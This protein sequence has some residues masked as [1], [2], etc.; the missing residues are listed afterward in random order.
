MEKSNSTGALAVLSA[1]SLLL[2]IFVG[3][4]SS[5]VVVAGVLILLFCGICNLV[6]AYLAFK[7]AEIVSRGSYTGARGYLLE[8]AIGAIVILIFTASILGESAWFPP[9]VWAFVCWIISIAFD[10]AGAIIYWRK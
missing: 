1:L 9:A 2:A 10:I 5:E 8:A 3:Q 6:A 4:G 7:G